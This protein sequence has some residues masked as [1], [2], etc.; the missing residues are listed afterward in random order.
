[1]TSYLDTQK[2]KKHELRRRDNNNF[3]LTSKTHV[4]LSFSFLFF[5]FDTCKLEIVVLTRTCHYIAKLVSFP[6]FFFVAIDKSQIM[7]QP[8]CREENPD[9]CAFE[10]QEVQ[11]FSLAIRSRDDCFNEEISI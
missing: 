5:L 9:R 8:K 11:G 10:L 2:K 6:F 4:Q 1:M 7:I 3:I